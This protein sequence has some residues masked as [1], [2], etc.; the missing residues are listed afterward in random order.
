VCCNYNANVKLM[1]I[2]PEE[3]TK[4]WKYDAVENKA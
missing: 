4:T 2:R 3:E 1:E